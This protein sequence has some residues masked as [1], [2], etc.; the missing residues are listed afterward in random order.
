VQTSINLPFVTA[1]QNGPKHLD[2]TLTRAK[3]EQL[4]ANLTERTVKPFE[5]AIRDA[6]LSVD[7]IKEVVLVGGATRMPV[8]QALVRRLTKKEPNQ[9]VNPD[10]VV[11]IGAAIQA[12]VLSGEVKDVVLLDVTPLTLGLE[13]LGEVGVSVEGDA[14]G[15]QR[16]HLLDR[17]REALRRLLGQAVDE[18]GVDGRV[19]QLAGALHQSLDH[20]ERLDPVHRILHIGVEVLHAD[21]H[22]VEAEAPERRDPRRVQAARSSSRGPRSGCSSI[23]CRLSI[24]RSGSVGFRIITPMMFTTAGA[25]I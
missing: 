5:N 14:V 18:V 24:R 1:D 17:A 25:R 21:A 10:E 12:G 16:P 4:T 20:P 2:Y 11:A 7:D 22:A 3:F 9:S 6:K 8:I 23:Y 19:A 13:T 15:T